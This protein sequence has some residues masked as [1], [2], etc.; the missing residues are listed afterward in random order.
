MRGCES[1]TVPAVSA[2]DDELGHIPDRLFADL[3]VGEECANSFYQGETRE[4][5][6]DGDQEGMV[7]GLG[8]IVR[9]VLV[10]E[11]AVWSQVH[12]VECA[13]VMDVEFHEVGQDWLLLAS[14][15]DYAD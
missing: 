4:L 13:E 10:A 15:W 2:D 6:V 7:A 8:P 12:G 9:E 3:N 11:P 1:D 14:G 5:I